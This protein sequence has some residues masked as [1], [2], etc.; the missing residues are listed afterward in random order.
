MP[1]IY[2]GKGKLLG[3]AAALAPWYLTGGIPLANCIAA[4]QPK[5]AASLAASYINLT[6]NATYDVTTG[7]APGW[8]ATNGWT[9]AG[10]QYLLT[11]VPL[12]VTTTTII[13]ISNTA[14]ASGAALGC[15]TPLDS[16]YRIY[17]DYSNVL[18]YSF[19]AISD[20]SNEAGTGVASGVI[21][22]AP[23]A[24]Y[25][26]GVSREAVTPTAGAGNI[27]IGADGA[28][29]TI[30]FVGYVQAVATY[31]IA[32]TGIQVLAVSNAA[33]AL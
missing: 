6:G 31:N 30:N 21:T 4:Y 7:A 8:G 20:P 29:H 28:G 24:I 19:S 13:R 26:D 25:V 14:S 12:L 5:G 11:N 1:I 10:A 33:A 3:G 16:C 32:L 17:P 2:G 15:T 18:Y 23:D 27:M 22:L 9:F